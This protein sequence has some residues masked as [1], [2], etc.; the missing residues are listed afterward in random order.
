[1]ENQRPMAFAFFNWRGRKRSSLL[2]RLFWGFV[3]LDSS[4]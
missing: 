1:M 4:C 2:L 3:L